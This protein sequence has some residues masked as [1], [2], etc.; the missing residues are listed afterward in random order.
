MRQIVIKN[1]FSYDITKN[2]N[3]NKNVR[4][5]KQKTKY[6]EQWLDRLK[7]HGPFELIKE[8]EIWLGDSELTS[9]FFL[10]DQSGL[11]SRSLA[12]CPLCAGITLSALRDHQCAHA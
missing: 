2:K 12:L 6:T 9:I 4:T 10:S 11:S 5:K 7:H 3:K 1:L 8:I